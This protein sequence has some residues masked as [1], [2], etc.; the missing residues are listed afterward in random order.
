MFTQ[1]ELVSTKNEVAVYWLDHN[2]HEQLPLTA[3]RGVRI[4]EADQYWKIN[5]VFTTLSQVDSLPAKA[6]IGTIVELN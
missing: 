3:G 5:R 1:V 2:I 6:R 4:A